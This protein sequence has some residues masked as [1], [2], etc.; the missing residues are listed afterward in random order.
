MNKSD[1]QKPKKF[2]IGP[3]VD[4]Q[5]RV[6]DCNIK[7]KCM[8]TILAVADLECLGNGHPD[9]ESLRYG[10]SCILLEIAEEH[11]KN[12][13]LLR[14]EYDRSPEAIIEK[15]VKACWTIQNG[16]CEDNHQGVELFQRH[17]WELESVVATFGDEYPKAKAT[18]ARLRGL[19]K[20]V[21]GSSPVAGNDVRQTG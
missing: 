11:E 18:L 17:V 21:F 7:L 6:N 14:A 12:I 13:E 4:A 3:I 15:A 9:G 20:N 2:D 10:L 8:G 1:L 16:Q 19:E 5:D